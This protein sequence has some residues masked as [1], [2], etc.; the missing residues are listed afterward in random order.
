MKWAILLYGLGISGGA[1]VIFEHALYAY[2]QGVEVT[3]ITK[4]N[5]IG[6]LLHGMW[7]QKNFYIK[8]LMKQEI[9]NM[10]L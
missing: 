7:G 2:N 10:M 4:K 5:K 1:N 6:Q 3:F 8:Q 9:I